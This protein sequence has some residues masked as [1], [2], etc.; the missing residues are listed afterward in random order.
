MNRMLTQVPAMTTLFVKWNAF[1]SVHS[2]IC[3][4]AHIHTHTITAFP[5]RLPHPAVFFHRS[6]PSRDQIHG[7]RR[8]ESSLTR[9]LEGE[10]DR[11]EE[12]GSRE[13]G[14]GAP[15][16]RGGRSTSGS[17]FLLWLLLLWFRNSGE[18]VVVVTED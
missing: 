9:D 15:P 5:A 7:I 16:R 11:R 6:A 17:D 1:T 4:C 13:R 18:R 8:R 12:T 10:L 3:V 14:E 2:N